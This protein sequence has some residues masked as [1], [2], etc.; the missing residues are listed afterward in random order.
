M[1]SCRFRWCTDFTDTSDSGHFGPFGTI[2]LVQRCPDIS[3]SVPKCPGETL[4]LVPKCLNFFHQ[5]FC[6][7]LICYSRRTI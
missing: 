7:F 5:I 3:A 2:R 1:I 4:A 6:Y